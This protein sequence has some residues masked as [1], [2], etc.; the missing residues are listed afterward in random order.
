MGEGQ[1]SLSSLDLDKLTEK[2]I[3]LEEENNT[4][5]YLGQIVLGVR[6]VPK[7]DAFDTGIGSLVK[8]SGSLT[9]VSS[10]AASS[11]SKEDKETAAK[12]L[13]RTHWSATVNIVLIEGQ[14]LQAM[15]E[16]GTSDP[17]CK[18]R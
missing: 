13:K 14:G 16:E 17:Y 12:S 9:H 4:S 15:D 3:T 5:E 18:V 7:S 11:A 6:L 10:A 8:A 2:I 1:V